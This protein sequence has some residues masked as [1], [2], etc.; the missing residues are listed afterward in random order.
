MNSNYTYH[1]LSISLL[2]S[3]AA[4]WAAAVQVPISNID[5]ALLKERVILLERISKAQGD[6]LNAL[7]QQLSEDQHDIDTLRGQIQK[8]A[9][10]INQTTNEQKQIYKQLDTLNQSI[11]QEE[12]ATPGTLGAKNSN[13]KYITTILE[14]NQ[15]DENN[16]YNAAL[17]LALKKKQYNTAILAFQSFIKQYPQSC[18]QSN[19]NY[20]LGQLF[21]NKGQKNDAAY[22]FA[23]VVRHYINSPKVPDAMYKIGVIMQEKGQ[24]DKASLVFR[25][26]IKQYPTSSAAALAKRCLTQ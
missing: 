3:I 22:Y 4:P 14:S 1:I 23:V 24:A 26:V 9:H 20:W 25:Q 12:T 13:K 18:Y 11:D 5:S 16:Y 8:N 17:A 21:Y 19:A 7:Q 15:E 2:I 10:Q 6:T